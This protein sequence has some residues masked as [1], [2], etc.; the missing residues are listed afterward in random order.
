MKQKSLNILLLLFTVF[1]FSTCTKFGKNVTVKGQVLNP[2][3][4][5]PISGIKVRLIKSQNLKYYGGYK[6]VKETTTD[7]NGHFELS[8]GRL[9][10]IWIVT[11]YNY[12]DYYDLG[13]DYD[14]KYY[15]QLKVD[16]GE[17]MHVDYHVVSYGKLN[18]DI[19]NVNCEG[20]SDTMRLRNK[21]EFDEDGYGSW[22]PLYYTG[23]YQKITGAS[24]VPEGKHTYQIEVKRTNM[25]TI[26]EF[27]GIVHKGQLTTIEIKY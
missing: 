9:G 27:S 10:S 14:G 15:S 17:V 24:K 12:K 8:A 21:W 19:K 5:Q 11:D 20:V 3:T 18:L 16:K 6:G 22:S 1:C 13:W 4:S 2:I 26:I 7:A 23:C 25:D